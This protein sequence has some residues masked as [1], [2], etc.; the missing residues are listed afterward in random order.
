M[1]C[2]CKNYLIL[3]D[4]VSGMGSGPVVEKLI[5]GKEEVIFIKEVAIKSFDKKS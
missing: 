4:E 2:F 5:N 3:A 1:T